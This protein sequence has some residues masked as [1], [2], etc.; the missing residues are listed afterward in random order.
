MKFFTWNEAK[1]EKL[2]VERGIGFEEVVFLIG[3]GDLLDV[4]E[5]PNQQRY[6]GQRIFVV[7]RGDYVYLVPFLEDDREVPQDHH[8]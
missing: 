5:H 3:K 4:L 2:K 6:R 1:N 7:R 8:S